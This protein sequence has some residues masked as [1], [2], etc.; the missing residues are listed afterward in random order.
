M[1]LVMALVAT[2]LDAAALA[3]RALARRVDVTVTSAATEETTAAMEAA[4]AAA[5]VAH[6]RVGITGTL[7][8]CGLGS[9]GL[10]YQW[11]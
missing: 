2:T 9:C 3:R 8:C 11:P 7:E 6:P 10:G 5:L 1:T 4:P